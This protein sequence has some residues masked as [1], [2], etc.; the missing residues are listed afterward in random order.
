[1]LSIG[2]VHEIDPGH[3]ACVDVGS[4]KSLVLCACM[5]T[6]R[7]TLVHRICKSYLSDWKEKQDNYYACMRTNNMGFVLAPAVAFSIKQK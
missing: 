1:M 3:H 5:H 4:S 6:G 2:A 7:D